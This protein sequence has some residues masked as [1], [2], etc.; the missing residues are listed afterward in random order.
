M[1][2]VV[3]A[4]LSLSLLLASDGQYI[5]DFGVKPCGEF[6][7][8]TYSI[9]PQDLDRCGICDR[10]ETNHHKY[11]AMTFA[12]DTKYWF[13][14]RD[15]GRTARNRME[16]VFSSDQHHMNFEVTSFVQPLQR[17]FSRAVQSC[18]NADTSHSARVQ[19]NGLWNCTLSATECNKRFSWSDVVCVQCQQKNRLLRWC[20]KT[21]N[22][23]TVT[24]DT[25]R[26]Y[27][28][29]GYKHL[30][31]G[32]WPSSD[33]R[34]QFLPGPC[35]PDVEQLQLDLLK[36]HTNRTYYE[37]QARH[38]EDQ[39]NS[40]QDQLEKCLET[41]PTNG[42]TTST[43][44][45]AKFTLLTT[46]AIVTNSVIGQT[47]FTAG[48]TLLAT[49]PTVFSRAVLPVNP[50]GTN[51]TISSGVCVMSC[52]QLYCQ[53]HG[54]CQW[55]CD[56]KENYT[57]QCHHLCFHEG[58]QHVRCYNIYWTATER[59]LYWT[60]Q[61]P[62][63][64]LI[65]LII[66]VLL[67]LFWLI[68]YRKAIWSVI[69]RIFSLPFCQMRGSVFTR[70]PRQHGFRTVVHMRGRQ[71]STHNIC[72][73]ILIFIFSCGCIRPV[74]GIT[75]GPGDFNRLFT[76]RSLGFTVE[77]AY[78][79]YNTTNSN[80][81]ACTGSH[82]YISAHMKCCSDECYAEGLNPQCHL[83]NHSK[84]GYSAHGGGG[85][86]D[87]CFCFSNNIYDATC[88]CDCDKDKRIYVHQTPDLG[89][90]IARGTVSIGNK[91][92]HWQANNTGTINIDVGSQN[93]TVTISGCITQNPG[94]YGTKE[95]INQPLDVTGCA[96][97]HNGYPLF[98]CSVNVNVGY[99]SAATTCHCPQQCNAPHKPIEGIQMN[100]GFE[101]FS[102]CNY[103]FKWTE[104]ECQSKTSASLV[105][106]MF[107]QQCLIVFNGTHGC[108]NGSAVPSG[109][110]LTVSCT[111]CTFNGTHWNGTVYD[112]NPF[113]TN[114]PKIDHGIGNWEMDIGNW[115]TKTWNKLTH[116]FGWGIW[117][118][119]TVVII[120]V[121]LF[122]I[123]MFNRHY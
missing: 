63:F 39:S 64:L 68:Y 41:S 91:T 33:E 100:H 21:Q 82:P 60:F 107:G 80:L 110:V 47:Q 45:L 48:I 103:N 84:C 57:G 92:H 23:L 79:W 93:M 70:T 118:L 9:V 44:T 7:Q 72:C 50:N 61:Q 122:L 28:G 75:I 10:Y 14:P 31:S 4:V 24:L 8:K 87:G 119:L 94:Q 13:Y 74:R 25:I 49:L 117:P 3:L 111:N 26:G 88:S 16:I 6:Y 120:I 116:L 19:C 95:G 98:G 123:C 15:Q 30:I 35:G 58:N 22:S 69:K 59:V 104:E 108:I 121:I 96:F 51:I 83:T 11:G 76:N 32:V 2:A 65:I 55:W 12:P 66:S 1:A 53:P 42:P 89:A 78:E 62:T 102:T 54:L 113:E 101:S 34:D 109:R 36:C 115:F 37:Q 73:M 97:W 52:N 46:F 105:G 77:R 86:S 99:Q 43:Q 18:S 114:H 40:Y 56:G 81:Y 112:F 5:H 29:K 85:W 90:F 20:F 67:L 17:C 71:I 38:W 106:C 27:A